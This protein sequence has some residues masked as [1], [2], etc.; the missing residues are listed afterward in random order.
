MDNVGSTV[1]LMEERRP[2]HLYDSIGVQNLPQ[3]H[4]DEDQI[5]GK[6]GLR[7]LYAC[8]CQMIVLW[9]RKSARNFD[10]MFLRSRYVSLLWNYG[11][12]K[13]DP[14]AISDSEAPQYASHSS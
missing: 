11:Q 9:T 5:V 6:E 1:K 14:G 12:Q 8:L 3:I 10:V 7:Y 13:L 2:E 4:N